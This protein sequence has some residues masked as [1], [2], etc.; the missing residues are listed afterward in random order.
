MTQV[1]T[2]K[3]D[4]LLVN[5]D[6]CPVVGEIRGA[7]DT[8]WTFKAYFKLNWRIFRGHI[9]TLRG[10]VRGVT[11]IDPFFDQIRD[12]PLFRL[13]FDASIFSLTKRDNSFLRKQMFWLSI[14]KSELH[15]VN[16]KR[17]TFA[18]IIKMWVKPET[19]EIRLRGI[20]TVKISQPT[21]THFSHICSQG[22]L[23]M[24]TS[25]S[26]HQNDCRSP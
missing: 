11:M 26:R 4:N 3:I 13:L 23:T 17:K 2:S 20:P 10:Q 24:S 25:Y 18:K 21:Q 12:P 22:G 5:L 14:C 7:L 19:K 6:P 16:R 8:R 15:G 1:W 9:T